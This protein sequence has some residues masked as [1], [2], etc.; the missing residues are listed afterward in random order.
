MGT[1]TVAMKLI[2]EIC[3]EKGIEERFLSFG[4]IRELEK[5]GKIK[6]IVRNDFDLNPAACK[7]IVNDKFATYEVLKVHNVPTLEYNVI[8]NPTTR[9]E[10]PSDIENKLHE[11]FVKYNG[12]IVLKQNNSSEGKGVFLFETEEEAVSRI[13]EI[14]EKDDNVNV[15]PFE[16]ID[17]EYRAV[18]L[19]GEVLFM[20]RKKKA[21]TG[22]KHNLANGATPEAVLEDDIDRKKVEEIA[23]SAGKAVG[24]RFVTVDISKTV[25]G[26]LFVMEING[27]V[28]MSRFAKSFPNGMQIS[29]GIYEKAID[30]MFE[31]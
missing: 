4:W 13:K 22:W 29:K 28:C 31:D 24:A 2:D 16:E 9:G 14:F 23:K 7:N 3:K 17:Y 25:D 18:F 26:R 8:F 10:Y 5:D 11:Y 6:H 21:E 1:N 20:Y 19:D 27:C 12:K 15:C 30:K